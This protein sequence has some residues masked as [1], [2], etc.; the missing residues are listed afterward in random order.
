VLL[1]AA[2]YVRPCRGIFPI[3]LVDLERS[4]SHVLNQSTRF[5]IAVRD[6]WTALS[7]AQPPQTT[8]L[9]RMRAAATQGYAKIALCVA[10]VADCEK[11]AWSDARCWPTAT[12]DRVLIGN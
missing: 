10:S 12:A 6:T 8:I 3:P 5:M 4:L 1:A 9:D 11:V 2:G 7:A